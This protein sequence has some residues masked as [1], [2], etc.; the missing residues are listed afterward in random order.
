MKTRSEQNRV[1]AY[2]L[3]VLRLFTFWKIIYLFIYLLF[4]YMYLFYLGVMTEF[5]RLDYVQVVE[6]VDKRSI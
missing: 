4:M 6:M 5:D 1:R 2:L 3:V